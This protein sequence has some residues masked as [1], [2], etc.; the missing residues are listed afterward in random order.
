M[1]SRCTDCRTLVYLQDFSDAVCANAS[2]LL[3]DWKRWWKP[4]E[5]TLNQKLT[6][7]F[8][9]F[10]ANL[11][12][13]VRTLGDPEK[14]FGQKFLD[15]GGLCRSTPAGHGSEQSS[16]AHITLVPSS[17]RRLGK[18]AASRMSS[19]RAKMIGATTKDQRSQTTIDVG[20]HQSHTSQKNTEYREG[21]DHTSKHPV[22]GQSG[23]RSTS[24]PSPLAR[25]VCNNLVAKDGP[26]SWPTARFA[27]SFASFALSDPAIRAC[28]HQDQLERFE[29]LLAQSAISH[30]DAI[31]R[32]TLAQPIIEDHSES[33]KSVAKSS[34]VPSLSRHAAPETSYRSSPLPR[35]ASSLASVPPSQDAG[36]DYSDDM[37]QSVAK[38]RLGAPGS[39]PDAWVQAA[40]TRVSF[41]SVS[42]C[43]AHKHCSLLQELISVSSLRG[44][45]MVHH[46]L[47][48]LWSQDPLRQPVQR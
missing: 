16:P 29:F 17:E 2:G 25:K 45:Q 39:E 40:G 36:S 46:R 20:A 48:P 33:Q 11:Q 38:S 28:L 3:D 9:R 43:R 18:G 31:R 37:A 27:A 21:S 24:E 14:L 35:S 42:L 23:S 6:S 30:L 15:A 4:S 7:E 47:S 13:I 22:S 10:S 5:P 34:C 12:A 8:Y 32:E 41:Y 19:G 44:L 26:E 1:E